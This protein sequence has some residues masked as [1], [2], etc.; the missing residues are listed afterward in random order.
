[1][2]T[3]RSRVTM[4][5]VARAAGVSHQTVSRVVNGSARVRPET[6]ARVRDAVAQ[7]AYRPSTSARNLAALRTREI[8][9]VSFVGPHFGPTTMLHSIESAARRHGYVTRIS[10]VYGLERAQV[11]VAVHELLQLD[12]DGAIVVAP[13]DADRG[14]LPDWPAHLPVLALESRLGPGRP[15]VASDNETGGA[16][17]AEHLLG[18]GHRRIGH[19]AG[20]CDWPESRLRT[21]GFERVVRA[22]GVELGPRLDGDWTAR[23][24]HAAGQRL[25]RAGVTAVFAANDQMALGVLTALHQAGLRVPEDVSVIGYDNTPDSGWYY[26]ALTTVEQ[27]FSAAG[28]AGIAQVVALIDGEEVAEELLIPPRLVRRAS[29]S[30]PPGGTLTGR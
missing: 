9:V 18:L 20:P 25:V 17:A 3:R 2:G 5:D 15:F 16:L 24:G 14:S 12:I 28:A 19:V 10:S 11:E 29:T 8:G 21:V 27:E 26:P 7:L 22:A 4:Y 23:S 1:V 30:A 13:T 6:E